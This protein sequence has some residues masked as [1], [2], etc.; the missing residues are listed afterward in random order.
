MTP[1][2]R[3]VWSESLTIDDVVVV[4]VVGTTLDDTN[5]DKGLVVPF[6]WT[7][8]TLKLAIEL[9]GFK[10]KAAGF[11]TDDETLA[12]DCPPDPLTR[13]ISTPLTY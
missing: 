10:D 8:L 13:S 6:F 12:T 7:G 3:S 4:V 5:D 2:R 9:K 1:V 11:V